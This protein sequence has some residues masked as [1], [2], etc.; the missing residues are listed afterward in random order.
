LSFY[1]AVLRASRGQS[2]GRLAGDDDEH[3]PGL[4]PP[5]SDKTKT[6]R[7]RSLG[8]FSTGLHRKYL[9]DAKA[10]LL[11]VASKDDFTVKYQA[12]NLVVMGMDFADLVG[13]HFPFH[14]L[15]E[16]VIA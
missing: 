16:A 8:V 14:N 10:T 4:A 2:G 6:G 15:A 5:A 1:Q 3:S 9:T 11:A 7:T 13:L 12:T